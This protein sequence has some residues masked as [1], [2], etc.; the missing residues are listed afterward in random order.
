MRKFSFTNIINLPFS[1]ARGD[2]R[3]VSPVSLPP[4]FQIPFPESPCFGHD[5]IIQVLSRSLISP[6]ENKQPIVLYGE[7]GSGKTHLVKTICYQNIGFFQGIH[8]IES[9]E[10]YEISF[11][12]AHAGRSLGITPWPEKLSDQI[13]ETIKDWEGKPNQLII[14]NH[15]DDPE[16]LKPWVKR[17]EQFSVLVTTQNPLWLS[18]FSVHP[19]KKISIEEC[20]ALLC[21]LSPRLEKYSAHSITSLIHRLDKLPLALDLAGRYLNEEI[22]LTLDNFLSEIRKTN[23]R[24]DDQAGQ[25]VK[26]KP[27]TVPTELAAVFSLTYRL[28]DSKG[29]RG[30]IAKEILTMASFCAP[31]FS[32]PLDLFRQSLENGSEKI[33][34]FENSLVI[35]YRLGLLQQTNHGPSIHQWIKELILIFN[36]NSLS[37]LRPLATAIADITN[38]MDVKDFSLHRYIPH[39]R[40]IAKKAEEE[41]FIQTG[42]LWSMLGAYL[43]AS[44]ELM[45]AKKYFERSL[46]IDAKT[47]DLNN[48][49]IANTNGNL[50]KVFYELGDLSS[51]KSCFEKALVITEKKFSPISNEVAIILNELGLVYFDLDDL[52]N[53]RKCFERA[54]SIH[55]IG[56]KPPSIAKEYANLGRVLRDLHDFHGAKNCFE[57]AISVDEWMFGPNH[58]TIANY[59]NYLGHILNN[60]GEVA[61]AKKCFERVYTLLEAANG[62]N[63]PGL[64]AV[65]NNLGMIYQDAGDLSKACDCFARVMQIDEN[66]Y[67]GEHPNIARDANNLGSALSASGDFPA[68]RDCFIRALKIGMKLYG[69]Y[70][71]N[72]AVYANNLARVLYNLGDLVG[73]KNAFERT[74]KIDKEL[75]GPNLIKAGTDL[76]NLATVFYDM[77]MI[78]EAKLNF[79]AALNIFEKEL[80]ADHPK[81]LKIRTYLENIAKNNS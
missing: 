44:A 77:G 47:N 10:P 57:R 71:P 35:L 78:Q 36:L 23:V 39:L 61:E 41:G 45:D 16:S 48:T 27:K 3:N 60:L 37:T 24:L 33:I 62:P 18:E 49:Q 8:W 1:K 5:D 29:E 26:N 30:R 19:L 28:L 6:S 52:S 32:I 51:A 50:G 2:Q 22:N 20:I 79:Q 31:N 17:L 75:F 9:G 69:D 7:P 25:Q 34:E 14:F 42:L 58:P 65:I 66:I 46:A 64:S 40:S 13:E 59:A 21:N 80:E 11:Q 81:T 70:H 53:A 43:Q 67:G 55:E 73:A 72:N 38:K 12:I 4:N 76:S 74:L 68:A 56:P 54:I 63:D 15:C